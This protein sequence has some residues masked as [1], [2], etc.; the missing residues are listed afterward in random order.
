MCKNQ[1]KAGA[2]A[3][4]AAVCSSRHDVQQQQQQQQQE[5]RCTAD[6]KI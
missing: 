1:F 2:E 5:R 6:Q 3:A 4:E